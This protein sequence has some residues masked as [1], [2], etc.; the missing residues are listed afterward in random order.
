MPAAEAC[1]PRHKCQREKGLRCSVRGSSA[2]NGKGP[3]REAADTAEVL[4][5]FLEPSQAP[6]GAASLY[7]DSR[8]QLPGRALTR[9]SVALAAVLALLGGL[10]ARTAHAQGCTTPSFITPSGSRII[11][12]PNVV[13]PGH[14]AVGDL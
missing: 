7:K 12:T 3:A 9:R 14:L 2:S 1:D 6:L 11:S 8:S 10:D 5:R 4:M 13:Q